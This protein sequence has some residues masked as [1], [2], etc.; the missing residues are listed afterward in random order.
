MDDVD[1]YYDYTGYDGEYAGNPEIP[2]ESPGTSVEEEGTNPSAVDVFDP[3]RFF[4]IDICEIPVSSSPSTYR[5]RSDIEPIA[6]VIPEAGRISIHPLGITEKPA[7]VSDAYWSSLDDRRSFATVEEI[8]SLA[9]DGLLTG[10]VTAV[11]DGGGTQEAV[12]T[13]DSG[14]Q[15]VTEEAPDPTEMP[16]LDHLEEFRWALLKTIFAVTVS[17]VASWFLTGIFYDTITRLAEDAE[18]PLVYHTVM[19]PV[20]IKLQM[21]LFMGLVIALPFSFY[22][23]WSFISPGLYK[24]EKKWILPIVIFATVSFLIG[25][26]IA[27]F[28]IVPLLLKLVS[29]FMDPDI[30]PFLSIGKFISHMLKFTIIFGVIFEMPLVSY[31]LAKIGIIKHT[32]MSRYRRYAIVVIFILG[33]V[34]T[35]PEPVS[36]I[37]MALPLVL[38]YEVSILVARIGG[39]KTLL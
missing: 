18:L 7:G 35:P 32:W 24:R 5:S 11:T 8:D 36:Q 6:A 34:F 12:D 10:A 9:V 16:F 27:Y 20:L 2:D 39:R 37:M 30:L 23:L 15:E 29:R 33:A 17:I 3:R 31:I 21:A 26:S 38:L 1:P 4:E 28:L 25:A 14:S 13:S 22:F 19:E